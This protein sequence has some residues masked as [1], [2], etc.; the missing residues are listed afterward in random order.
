VRGV[1][2]HAGEEAVS[3]ALTLTERTELV[4]LEAVIERGLATF[5]EV[6]S[7]LLNV[8]DRRLY[9]ETHRSFEAYLDERWHMS[10]PRAYQLIEAADVS[11]VVDTAGLPALANERQA[12]E[13]AAVLRD[14]GEHALLEV[15]RELRN[16]YG[17]DVTAEKIRALVTGRLARDRQVRSLQPVAT[18][19][20]P[21]GRYR[22]IVA[23][24][25]WYL[26]PTGPRSGDGWLD[27]EGYH[28]VL[29]YPTMT[30][31]EIKALPVRDLAADDAHLYLWTIN[32]YL[33]HA[34]SVARAWD[35]EPSTVITWAKKPRGLGLGGP[36]VLTTEHILFCRR[37]TLKATG[38]HDSTWYQWPRGRHSAK[39][40]A[41]LDLVEHVSP[42]PYVE[43]FARRQRPG[44]TCWGNEAPAEE[45]A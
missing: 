22:T 12:R 20:L 40:E 23:D 44:W 38:R 4:E 5:A 35:F 33:E 14:E 45:A 27:A 28:S 30:L 6:G 39:P 11:T 41:F 36:W 7:A 3:T 1:N 16:E 24:P 17:D 43:L 26:P 19:P 2:A 25:P 32:R 10:R 9:R 34:Y 42:G 29:P 8:R 18:P 31:E 13:L 21:A 15:C 37:G